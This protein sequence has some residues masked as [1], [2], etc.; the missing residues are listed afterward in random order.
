MK[1]E[2]Q[3]RL[4]REAEIWRATRG[5]DYSRLEGEIGRNR[6]D[7][8]KRRAA[9]EDHLAQREHGFRSMA[10]YFLALYGHVPSTKRNR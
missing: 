5:P 8:Q 6:Q 3:K 2:D 4:D 1:D 9:Y 10:H 7:A